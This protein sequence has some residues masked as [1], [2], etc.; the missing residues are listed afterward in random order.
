MGWVMALDFISG[1]LI[2]NKSAGFIVVVAESLK[3][4]PWWRYH[5]L[6][7]N[8]N[9]ADMGVSDADTFAVYSIET[10]KIVWTVADNGKGGHVLRIHNSTSPN[11]TI[12]THAN[13]VNAISIKGDPHLCTG[14]KHSGCDKEDTLRLDSSGL[15]FAWDL[16]ANVKTSTSSVRDMKW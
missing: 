3:A 12:R 6:L 15:S 13:K 11:L 5:A 2:S 7:P 10:G 4:A 8:A 1:G 14:E 16:P 9:T